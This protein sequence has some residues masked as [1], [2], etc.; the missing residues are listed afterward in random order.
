MAASWPRSAFCVV[1]D[2][3]ERCASGKTGTKLCVC[4]L[5]Q[6]LSSMTPNSIALSLWDPLGRGSPRDSPLA[7][8]TP[9]LTSSIALS[10]RERVR[11]RVGVR[12]RGDV[13]SHRLSVTSGQLI[14]TSFR[15]DQ[16]DKFAAGLGC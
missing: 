11:E 9:A 14:P 3:T 8:L 10:L 15:Q 2:R 5:K 6:R 1:L 4:R 16:G 7:A 12:G 13:D